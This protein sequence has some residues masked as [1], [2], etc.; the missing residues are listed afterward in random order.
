MSSVRCVFDTNTIVSGVLFERSKPGRA[1][2]RAIK[3]GE[4]LLSRSTL[5]EL[6]EV[7]LRPKF[8][9]YVTSSER[10]EFL[11]AFVDRATWV[12]PSEEIHLCRDP[13][14]DKSLEPA[15]GGNADFV[16]SGDGDLLALHPF[17]GISIMT[18]AEFLTASG[19]QE[20]G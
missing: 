11:E 6:A 14:D 16:I 9:R 10:E 17:R 4:V 1:F 8:D 19:E 20:E 13:K 5:E 3:H 12:E 15:I 18:S 7:L 2:L